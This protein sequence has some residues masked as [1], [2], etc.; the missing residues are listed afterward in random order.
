MLN[1]NPH[2]N[3]YKERTINK[4]AFNTYQTYSIINHPS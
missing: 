3:N 4:I 1:I 2:G